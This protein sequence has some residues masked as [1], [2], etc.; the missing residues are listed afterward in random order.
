M[1]YQ[2]RVADANT[3][4]AVVVLSLWLICEGF[5]WEAWSMR[6]ED[7]EWVVWLCEVVEMIL[8]LSS[9]AMRHVR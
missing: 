1:A 3:R 5:G 2:K 4:S 8:G 6:G 9:S 7:G